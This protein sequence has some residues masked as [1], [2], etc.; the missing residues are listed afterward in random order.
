MWMTSTRSALLGAGIGATSMFLLDPARG[1]RRRS[2]LRDKA[3]RAQRK[4]RDVAGATWRDLN[5]RMT[6]LRARR[7][8]RRRWSPSALLVAS[9]SLGAIALGSAAAR[10]SN[11]TP[12]ADINTW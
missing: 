2:L 6:G 3:M 10:R 1:A 5:N 12:F 9:A 11:G 4:T 7:R 8:L